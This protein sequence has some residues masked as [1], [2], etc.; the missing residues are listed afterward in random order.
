[1][2]AFFLQIAPKTFYFFRPNKDYNFECSASSLPELKHK[3][4]GP[5]YQ[6]LI[7]KNAAKGDLLL[8][9]DSRV[10]F[11]TNFSTVPNHAKIV[12]FLPGELQ[13]P[14]KKKPGF[15][16]GQLHLRLTFSLRVTCKVA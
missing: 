1:M 8:I 3:L 9:H 5:I 7:G 15:L 14:S 13:S 2:T 10:I 11:E 16:S 6:P 12:I 4:K